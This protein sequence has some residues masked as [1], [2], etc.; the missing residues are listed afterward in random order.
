MSFIRFKTVPDQTELKHMMGTDLAKLMFDSTDPKIQE[1]LGMKPPMEGP[2]EEL[3]VSPSDCLIGHVKLKP[4]LT[5][6]YIKALTH[7]GILR[8]YLCLCDCM[9][10]FTSCV[11]CQSLVSTQNVDLWNV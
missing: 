9:I 2:G 4:P 5:N 10:S 3:W 8:K 1:M 11:F 6:K 7:Q